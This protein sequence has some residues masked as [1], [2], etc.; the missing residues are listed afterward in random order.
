MTNQGNLPVIQWRR[1]IQPIDFGSG[2]VNTYQEIETI[3]FYVLSLSIT[4]LPTFQVIFSF[5]I[6]HLNNRYDVEF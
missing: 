1:F 2:R 3:M 4:T 6:T 5:T